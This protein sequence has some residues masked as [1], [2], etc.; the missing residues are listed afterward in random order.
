MRNGLLSAYR[1]TD[2]RYP[3]LGSQ[4]RP[5]SLPIS[6]HLSEY[7]GKMLRSEIFSDLS[8]CY[9]EQ[10]VYKRYISDYCDGNDPMDSEEHIR[11][12]MKLSKGEEIV[13]L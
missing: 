4:S 13:D 10:S 2:K 12:M 3:A 9:L 5:S 7:D 6:G 11:L 8:G 1:L